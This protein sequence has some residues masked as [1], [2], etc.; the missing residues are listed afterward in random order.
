MVDLRYF[1]LFPNNQN[2]KNQRFTPSGCNDIRIIKILVHDK[3]SIPTRFDGLNSEEK[4]FS[5]N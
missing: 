4:F 2:L 1:Q 5:E 3:D